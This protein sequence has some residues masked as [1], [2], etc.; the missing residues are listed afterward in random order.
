MTGEDKL[1]WPAVRLISPYVGF[2][3]C[4]Y[5]VYGIL[6]ESL[7]VDESLSSLKH[8]LFW[9]PTCFLFMG[10]FMRIAERE[11]NDRI[12]KQIQALEASVAE[13]NEKPS[14]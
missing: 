5:M 11:Q 10:L 7:F 2:I 12:Q 13:L 1:F 9:L 4:G 6:G 14:R 3:T 8:F